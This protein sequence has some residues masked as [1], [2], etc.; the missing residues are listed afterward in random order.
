MLVT[1]LAMFL[2]MLLAGNALGT[3]LHD[4][5]DALHDLDIAL[6]DLDIALNVLSA[7]DNALAALSAVLHFGTI[8]CLLLVLLHM[9]IV[10]LSA[11]VCLPPVIG[12]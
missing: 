8:F 10:V 5:D 2:V 12:D 6:R 3:A 1:V 11:L 7:P 9:I 4:L